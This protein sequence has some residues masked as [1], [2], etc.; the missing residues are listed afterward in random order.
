MIALVHIYVL[1]WL[2][3]VF[4]LILGI[5]KKCGLLIHDKRYV[6]VAHVE[7]DGAI[8]TLLVGMIVKHDFYLG[9]A[10]DGRPTDKDESRRDGPHGAQFRQDISETI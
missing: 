3:Y 8:D 2:C 4:S 7:D 9:T 10:S 6:L 5:C 1:Q